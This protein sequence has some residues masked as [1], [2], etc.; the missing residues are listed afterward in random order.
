MSDFIEAASP[1]LITTYGRLPISLSH[2]HG[3]W[4]GDDNDQQYL[5][6]L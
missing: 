3:G 5:A 4:A 1:R 6:G 2:G